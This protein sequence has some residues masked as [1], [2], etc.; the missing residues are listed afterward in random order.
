M[1]DV[2]KVLAGLAKARGSFRVLKKSGKNPHLKNQYSTLADM[3]EACG[4]ALADNGLTMVQVGA[5]R[6]GRHGLLTALYA[7]DGS[8]I[9]SF[10]VIDSKAGDAQ[11]YGSWITYLRRYALAAMLGLEG[12]WDDDGEAAVGRGPAPR[13]QA[14]P[15]A[16]EANPDRAEL[17]K[18]EA[19]FAA[20][21]V[22]GAQMEAFLKHPLMET[23]DFEVQLLRDVY[24]DMK[25]GASWEQAIFK[26][27]GGKT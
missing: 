14:A 24:R 17:A 20:L 10:M 25:S 23:R 19:A 18:L 2:S 27:Q 22:T 3:L 8:A 21:K 15:A 5:M 16:S 9:E 11:A 6:D 12:D 1:N 4:S 7:A 13:E 26:P